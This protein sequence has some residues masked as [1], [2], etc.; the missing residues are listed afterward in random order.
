MPHVVDDEGD[1]AERDH[2]GDAVFHHIAQ[3]AI[4]GV[5]IDGERNRNRQRCGSARKS[6]H[7]EAEP[8]IRA[9]AEQAG[10]VADL[11]EQGRDGIA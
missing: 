10:E 11:A 8:A 3:R 6:R 4:A 1:Q 5:E 9:I 2:G 7:D